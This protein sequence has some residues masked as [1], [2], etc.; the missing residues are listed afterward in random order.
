MPRPWPVESGALDDPPRP[1]IEIWV[2]GKQEEGRQLRDDRNISTA[3]NSRSN[4]SK[5][6]H[7]RLRG[8]AALHAARSQVHGA[9]GL[10][11]GASQPQVSA[12]KLNL[13]G[14]SE[15]LYAFL[16]ADSALRDKLH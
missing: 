12:V 8:F 9:S 14:R 6:E 3:G 2:A 16:R 4:S 11:V 5:R 1:A 13:D 7:G 10:G 15:A